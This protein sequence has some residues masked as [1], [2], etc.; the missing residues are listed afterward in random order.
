MLRGAQHLVSPGDRRGP[1]G[2][3]AALSMTRQE[4]FF[5]A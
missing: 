2:C 1:R 4:A 5:T 3:F